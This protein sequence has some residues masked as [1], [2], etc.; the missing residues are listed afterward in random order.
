MDTEV[1]INDISIEMNTEINNTEQNTNNERILSKSNKEVTVTPR[2]SS[3]TALDIYS[4]IRNKKET[5]LLDLLEEKNKKIATLEMKIATLEKEVKERTTEPEEDRTTKKRKLGN[6]GEA[7]NENLEKENLRKQVENLTERLGEREGEL[8][9]AREKLAESEWKEASTLPTPKTKEVAQPQPDIKRIIQE[10]QENMEKRFTEMEKTIKNSIASEKEKPQDGV[11]TY[12][13]VA[14]NIKEIR[15]NTEGLKSPARTEM[16]EKRNEELAE[17]RE[18]KMREK[19]I[20]IHGKAESDE[21]VD[22][23]FLQKLIKQIAVGS[24]KFKSFKRIGAMSDAKKRPIL[25]Q[26]YNTEDKYKV[27]NNLRNLKDVYLTDT[28]FSNLSVTDDYTS[29][30]RDII[31]VFHQKAASLNEN[32]TDQDYVYKVR[33]TPKNGMFLKKLRKLSA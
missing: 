13:D 17:V 16:M 28:D 14:S 25:V 2:R 4:E 8:H 24:I 30:E 12:A 22:E 5:E 31:K 32:N 10:I 29:A 33:G 9:E 11:A 1:D 6:F 3:N 23:A 21:K 7:S 26:F 15:Q 27:M 18:K 19:N 20:V